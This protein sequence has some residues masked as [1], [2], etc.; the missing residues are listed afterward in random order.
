MY[1]YDQPLDIDEAG[2]LGLSLLDYHGLLQGGLGGLVGAIESSHSQAPLMPAL[3]AVLYCVTGAHVISGF[4][5]PLLAGAAVIAATYYL[6]IALGSRCVAAVSTVLTATCPIILSYSRS[7]NF[8][9][10]ATFMATMAMVALLRSDRF[11]RIGWALVFGVSVGLMPLARTMTLAFI[12]GILSAA[13]VYTIVDRSD[14]HRRFLNLFGSLL[15]AMAIAST[16]LWPNGRSVFGYLINFGYGA[17]AAEYGTSHAGFGFVNWL[18]TVETFIAFVNLPHFLVM[19]AGA[20]ALLWLVGRSIS[21]NFFEFLGSVAHTSVLPVF[22]YVTEALLV[23][24]STQNKGSAFIAPIVPA[25]IVLSVWSCRKLSN[26]RIYRWAMAMA[27]LLVSLLAI[28]PSI[29]LKSARICIV[30][31]PVLGPSTVFDGRG[32]IQLYEAAGGFA[33]SDPSE[34]ISLADGRTWL[35]VTRATASKIRQLGGSQSVTAF[36]FRHRLYNLNMVGL[37]EWIEYGYQTSIVQ[38][39]P[40]VTGDSVAGDL[41]WLTH[42]DAEKASL[43]LIIADDKYQFTPVVNHFRMINAA[44]QAG[45]QNVAR[46]ALPNGQT[47]LLWQRSSQ[48]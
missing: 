48:S 46:W 34:P 28:A 1:R 29:D 42:G 45:F 36:G 27:V 38:V 7:Y 43:L 11:R 21:C 20:L 24:T 17:H 31:L 39:D 26:N 47:V 9:L 23:L 18:Y 25:V 12:P 44:Q 40:L 35:A 6:G 16:W 2:Y 33:T 10:L 30:N 5:V 14:R 22:L 37:Q 8:S 32:T 4:L 3:T 19:L 13:I 41:N 15:L